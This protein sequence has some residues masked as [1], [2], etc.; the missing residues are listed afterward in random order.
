MNGKLE[1]KVALVTG[2]ASGIGR[3]V[4]LRFAREGAKVAVIDLNLHGA[5]E[6]VREIE[7]LGR[8]AIAIQCDVGEEGQVISAVKTVE[9]NFGRIDI[10]VNNAGIMIGGFF[11]DITLNDWHKM[12]KVHVDGTFLFSKAVIKNMKEGGRIL[13]MSSVSAFGDPF[14]SAYSAVKA[15]IIGF[16]KSIAQEV[17][18]RGITVNAIVGG[19][20]STPMTQITEKM[21]PDLPKS[22]PIHRWGT[23]EDIASIMTYLASDEAS[24]ITGQAII[25]DGGWTL[26]KAGMPV[27]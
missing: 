14:V 23:A 17:A 26:T 27:I 18:S 3:A 20:I 13:N 22:I 9:N 6:V 25:V 15:A 19:E 21:F 24:Y 2:G 1:G 8:E 11:W 5:R 7:N 4:S 16:T 12:F 10:L